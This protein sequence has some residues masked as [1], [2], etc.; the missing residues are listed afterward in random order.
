M[1]T[2]LEHAS[3]AAPVTGTGRIILLLALVAF[4]SA[5]SMRVMDAAIPQLAID[6]DVGIR[7]AASVVTVFAIAYG[8]LQIVFGPSGDRF[9]KLRVILFACMCASLASVACALA[10]SFTLLLVAR[11]AAGASMASMMPLSMAWIGD[12][13]AYEDRQPVLA[14]FL[15]GQIA[16]LAVGQAAGGIATDLVSWRLPFWFLALWFVAMA[17]LL[18]RLVRT[19]AQRAVVGASAAFGLVAQCRSVLAQRW[20]RCVLLTVFLEGAALYGPFA[21][22][23]THL[24]VKHGLSL[25]LA[26]SML[27]AFALGGMSYAFGAGRLLRRLGEAGLARGGAILLATGI[28]VVA[29]GPTDVPTALFAMPGLFAAGLG[30]YML[31]NT[32]QIN[33]TQM[34]PHAR[35][36]AVALFASCFFLGQSVGVALGGYAVERVATTPVMLAGA[37]ALLMVGIGFS[38]LRANRDVSS[39]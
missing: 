10:P 34:A 32:L 5:M 11:A 23:A 9:G 17:V 20:A 37:L 28:A 27:V 33:A 38:A 26:G 1:T 7:N 19:P 29:L 8:C 2:T 39:G 31:H 14:R 24:H 25:S 22:F 12:N 36:T 21:F 18:T 13:V 30:F 35:G 16:G 4:G 15:V 3:P 6:F